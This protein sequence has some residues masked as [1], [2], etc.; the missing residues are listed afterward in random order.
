MPIGQVGSPPVKNLP[1]HTAANQDQSQ[2]PEIPDAKVQ[3]MHV[4]QQQQAANERQD[5]SR[6]AAWASQ[7]LQGLDSKAIKTTG[8]NLK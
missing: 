4:V 8:Q 3:P 6:K 7:G 2:P 5:E 1:K